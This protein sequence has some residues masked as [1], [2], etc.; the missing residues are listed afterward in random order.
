MVG[1]LPRRV[2]IGTVELVVV[3]PKGRFPTAAEITIGQGQPRS[4]A[5]EPLQA[6]GTLFPPSP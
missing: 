4:T 1:S 3:G 6:V 2:D 5:F